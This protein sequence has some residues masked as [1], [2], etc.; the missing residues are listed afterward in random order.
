MCLRLRFGRGVGEPHLPPPSPAL[1]FIYSTLSFFSSLGFPPHLFWH[2]LQSAV[3]H[4]LTSV[5]FR[6]AHGLPCSEPFLSFFAFLPLSISLFSIFPSFPSTSIFYCFHPSLSI[7]LFSSFCLYSLFYFL[8][9][10]IILSLFPEPLAFVSLDDHRHHQ[11]HS[12][13][14]SLCR[15]K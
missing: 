1:S 13:K 2:S 3:L 9:I 5:L 12:Q 11:W 7:F 15:I 8:S 14:S 10:S 4:L 6:M